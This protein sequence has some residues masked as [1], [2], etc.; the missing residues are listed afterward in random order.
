MQG[1]N[2][3]S[4]LVG[5]GADR[6]CHALSLKPQ[7]HFRSSA[8]GLVLDLECA[9]G[10]TLWFMK[11]N[12]GR[13]N[14]SISAIG[15]GCWAI[16][17]EWNFDTQAAGWGSVDDLESIAAISA[18]VEMGVTFFDTAANYGAGH[19]EVILG[20]ALGTDRSKVV[21]ATKFGYGVDEAQK[22]VSGVYCSPNDIRSSCT[23]SLRRLQTDYIDL[24]QLHVGNYPVTDALEIRDTLETLVQEGLIRAYGWSTDDTTRA[25]VFATGKN[26]VAIQHQ[27]NIFEDNAAMVELV[28]RHRLSS[29]NRGPLGM[30]ILTGKFSNGA[31]F[32]QSDV[33]H[34]SPE[35]MA[36]FKNGQ[37]NAEWLAKLE[38]IREIL[39]AGGRTLAQGSLA[40]LLARSEQTIP[41]PGFRTVKQVRENAAV[42]EQGALSTLQMQEITVLLQGK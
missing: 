15:M 42:L 16:G 30:G 39:C 36:Y 11:R 33:R 25:E 24:F 32:E 31:T 14:T 26:C 12:L 1:V 10:F 3:D 8:E 23:A 41:I 6:E 37:P 21:I 40:W 34:V 7:V 20:K 28:E 38:A 2:A 22:V 19:S 5:G 9:K 35:W 18:A 29:I 17:G 13:S 4:G 27:E